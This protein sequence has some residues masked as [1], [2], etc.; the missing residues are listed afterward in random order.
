VSGQCSCGIFYIQQWIHFSLYLR[1]LCTGYKGISSIQRTPA[2]IAILMSF[3][4]KIYNNSLKN[5]L[6]MEAWKLSS[7]GRVKMAAVHAKRV[8]QLALGA[9]LWISL[10]KFTILVLVGTQFSQYCKRTYFGTFYLSGLFLW[11]I[12]LKLVILEQLIF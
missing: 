12:Q 3:C 7:N 9:D 2:F 6:W 5:H 10:D 4:G 1:C 11:P 8:L